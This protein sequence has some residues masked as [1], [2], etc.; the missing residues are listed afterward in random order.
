MTASLFAAN[1]ISI[2]P[3]RGGEGREKTKAIV[4]ELNFNPP[5]P[6]GGGTNNGGDS[7]NSGKISIHPPRGGEGLQ[8]VIWRILAT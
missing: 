1:Y 7:G 3:P 6:W 4:R 5:S 8:L 2:H